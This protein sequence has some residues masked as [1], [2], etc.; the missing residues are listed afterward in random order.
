MP[1]LLLFLPRAHYS[2]I[3]DALLKDDPVSRAGILFRD[4]KGLTPS[5]DGFYC[6]VSAPEPTIERAKGVAAG[7]EVV[8]GAERDK[9]LQTV[10]SQGDA[11]AEGFGAIFG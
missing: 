9:I 2:K 4:A 3:R 1:D 7:A 10:K 6:I 8:A 11:A 5:R